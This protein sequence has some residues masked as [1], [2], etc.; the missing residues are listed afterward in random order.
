MEYFAISEKSRLFL[1]LFI[2]QVQIQNF[3]NENQSN[4]AHG[5]LR[6][7]RRHSVSEFKN[8]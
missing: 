1:L 5:Q 7:R 3:E 4:F 8:I 2:N 6:R